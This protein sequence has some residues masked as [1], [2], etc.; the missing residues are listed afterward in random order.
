MPK[1]IH[2]PVEKSGSESPLCALE[3]CILADSTVSSIVQGLQKHYKNILLLMVAKKK[4][5]VHHV[6]CKKV[7]GSLTT[8]LVENHSH[9]FSKTSQA[10]LQKLK[11]FSYVFGE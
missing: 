3:I 11:L 7:K 6:I 2:Q 9:P 4:E 10:N 5:G 1:V 8:A